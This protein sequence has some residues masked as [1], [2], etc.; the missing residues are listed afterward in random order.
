MRPDEYLSA[1]YGPKKRVVFRSAKDDQEVLYVSKP[2]DVNCN[3]ALNHSREWTY[4]SRSFP[5][6]RPF[7]A[8]PCGFADTQGVALG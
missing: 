6:F 1:Q 3:L 4:I 5:M 2:A 8:G 7:R